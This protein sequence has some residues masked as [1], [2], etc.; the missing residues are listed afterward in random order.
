MTRVK[1]EG[2]A[3]TLESEGGIA[4]AMGLHL[5]DQLAFTLFVV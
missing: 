5:N 1:A 3:I 4:V 2:Y